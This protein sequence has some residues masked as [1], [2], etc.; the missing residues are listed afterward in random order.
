MTGLKRMLNDEIEKRG[1][2]TINEVHDFAKSLNHKESTAERR[3][4]ASESP[5]IRTVRDEKGNN[6]RYEFMFQKKEAD[7]LFKTTDERVI[8]NKDLIRYS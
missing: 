7:T 1:Y 6:I 8:S 5:N 3:L 4:R 2:M